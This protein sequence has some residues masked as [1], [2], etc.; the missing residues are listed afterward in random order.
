MTETKR[1]LKWYFIIISIIGL[2]NITNF[3]TINGDVIMGIFLSISVIF[4]GIFLYIGIK[5][6]ELLS[7]SQKFIINN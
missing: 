3:S 2:W 1:S 4:G 7:K 5:F 6:D